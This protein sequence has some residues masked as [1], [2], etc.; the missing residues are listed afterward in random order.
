[1]LLVKDTIKGK[2]VAAEGEIPEQEIEVEILQCENLEECIQDAGSENNLRDAY[3]D[4]K[5]NRAL[6]AGRNQYRNAPK[7]TIVS[8]LI[9]KVKN[10]VKN[11]SLSESERGM[12]VKKKAEKVDMLKAA[13]EA[14][15][16]FSREELLAMLASR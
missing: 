13:L 8:E 7:G 5:R 3:N 6:T 14:G 16:E 15:K 12:G 4:H 2:N 10:T 11:F 1:M 9:E